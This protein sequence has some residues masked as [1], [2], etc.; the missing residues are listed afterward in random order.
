MSGGGGSSSKKKTTT[1]APTASPLIPA[2]QTYQPFMP[3]FENMLAQQ[4]SAGYGGGGGAPDFMSMLTNMYKPV[5]LSPVKL[6]ISTDK[7]KDKK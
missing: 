6:P 7:D 3:G 5:T 1:A 2:A 4:L